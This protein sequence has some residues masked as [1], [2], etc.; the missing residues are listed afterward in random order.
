MFAEAEITA[1]G[2]PALVTVTLCVNVHPF[3]SVTV[4]V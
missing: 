4:Q 1:E 2:E 3:A